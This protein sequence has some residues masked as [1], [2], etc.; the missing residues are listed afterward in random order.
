MTKIL[1]FLIV[2]EKTGLSRSTIYLK[3]SKVISL[4]QFHW[5]QTQLDGWK[6]TFQEWINSRIS[7]RDQLRA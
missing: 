4:N 7:E 1:R 2:I 5:V 3:V 6:T